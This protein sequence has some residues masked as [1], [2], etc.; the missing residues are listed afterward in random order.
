MVQVDTDRILARTVKGQATAMRSNCLID[1][2][3]QLLQ[4]AA[5]VPQIRRAL[6]LQFRSGATKVTACYYLQFY[7]H[8]AAVIQQL[9]FDHV[10]LTVTCLDLAH[11]GHGDVIGSGA[12]RLYLARVG[13]N[14]FIPLFQRAGAS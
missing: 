9:G 6:Q 8:A 4:P 2:L 10:L 11:R 12:R 13:Q 3:R 7:F 14:H 1:S 5:K